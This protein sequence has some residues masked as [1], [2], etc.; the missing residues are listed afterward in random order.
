MWMVKDFSPIQSCHHHAVAQLDNA[1]CGL[2]QLGV[3]G[4]EDNREAVALVQLL[5]DR[6][7]LVAAG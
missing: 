4:N 1:V 5:Q 7:D 2:G 6:A 3:V